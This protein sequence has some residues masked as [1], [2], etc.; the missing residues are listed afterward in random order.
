VSRSQSQGPGTRAAQQGS[1]RR[2]A[3]VRPLQP[4]AEAQ[5]DAELVA[6]ALGGDRWAEEALYRRHVASV[7]NVALR[8]LGRSDEAD[9]VV[10]DSF[11]I[12]LEE[13]AS[14][15]QPEAFG[16]WVRRI[17]VRQAHR[18]FRRRRLL[19]R[20]GLDRGLDDAGLY[21]LAS[22]S[23]APDAQAEL[24][25]LDRRLK[26][27]PADER[28]AWILRHV[29]G[30]ALADVAALCGCSLATVKR[31]LSRAQARVAAQLRDAS[32]APQEV[33]P[34]EATGTLGAEEG[35][36]GGRHG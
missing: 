24:L 8:L 19:A 4:R 27:L 32:D 25:G 13:L 14:L 34:D 2:P 36:A 7:S 30:Y 23:L 22:P 21:Q 16:S 11:V 33:P 26:R 3:S 15:R 9:D 18:R 6:R 28:F 35:R 1:L 5:G 10:Q 20:L 29:E 12:A 17:A 31:R